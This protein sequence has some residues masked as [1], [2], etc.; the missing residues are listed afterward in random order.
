MT[1]SERDAIASPAL[2]LL[3]FQS[4]GS[5]GFYFYDGTTW[6]LLGG[7]L[8]LTSGTGIP[9][10]TGAAGDV[11]VDEST[12][13]IYASDGTGWTKQNEDNQTATDVGVTAIG[14]L[15]QL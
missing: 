13:D 14:N 7:L 12:G 3:I 11:Y 8:Q 1:E 5:S 15:P 4:D 10:G 6:K 9:D 2:G